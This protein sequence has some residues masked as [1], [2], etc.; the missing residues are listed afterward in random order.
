MMLRAKVRHFTF[1]ANR[2]FGYVPY[3][4]PSWLFLPKLRTWGLSFGFWFFELWLG[5]CNPPANGLDRTNR[6]WAK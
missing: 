1:G 6:N 4:G 2:R 3:L 5:Y